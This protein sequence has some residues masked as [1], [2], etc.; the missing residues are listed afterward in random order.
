MFETDRCSYHIE[1]RWTKSKG[2]S[3]ANMKEVVAELGEVRLELAGGKNDEK[4]LGPGRIS[5]VQPT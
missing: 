3:W 4:R 5:Q 2:R 1:N